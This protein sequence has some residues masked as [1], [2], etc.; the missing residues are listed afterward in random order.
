MIKELTTS[1]IKKLITK[2]VALE[3]DNDGKE[4]LSN[5]LPKLYPHILENVLVD[6][7]HRF[8]ILKNK[9]PYNMVMDVFK[10]IGMEGHGA[11]AN[12]EFRHFC[13]ALFGEKDYVLVYSNQTLEYYQ[14]DTLKS[15]VGEKFDE[16]VDFS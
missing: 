14:E 2:S 8:L 12:V 13:M 7:D 11:M 9:S 6:L 10:T 1:E 16:T 4:Y 5:M 3:M 15:R